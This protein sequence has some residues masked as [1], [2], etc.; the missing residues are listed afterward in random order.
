MR[1]THSRSTDTNNTNGENERRQF[2]RVNF[3]ASA[4]ITQE[5]VQ[6]ESHVIDISLNGVL[7]TTPDNYQLNSDRTAQ[8]DIA[9][10]NNSHIRMSVTLVHSSNYVLGLRCE[11]IDMESV[12]HLRRLIELN[13][14]D[15]N[16]SDRI[17]SELLKSH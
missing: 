11:S 2:T 16:A 6:F 3:D 12:T 7:L 10:D 17:L 4:K 15:K 13:M 9:L 14:G 1:N 8:L 5:S